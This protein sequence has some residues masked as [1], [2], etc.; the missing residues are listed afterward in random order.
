[1]EYKYDVFVSYN[2]LD[3]EITSQIVT[4]LESSGLKTFYDRSETPAGTIF[5]DF[6]Q[7]KL[8]SSRCILVI[9]S[10]NSLKSKWVQYEAMEGFRREVLVPI[11]ID[12]IEP[13]GIFKTQ[14]ILDFISFSSNNYESTIF[15]KLINDINNLITDRSFIPSTLTSSLNIEKTDLEKPDNHLFYCNKEGWYETKDHRLMIK[16][17]YKTEVDK[18]W[19]L[20][21]NEKMKQNDFD[22]SDFIFPH[23]TEDNFWL[24]D[25]KRVFPKSIYFQSARFIAG[26][27]FGSVDFKGITKFEGCHFSE[28]SYFQSANFSNPVNFNHSTFSGIADFGLSFFREQAVFNETKFKSNVKFNLALLEG[29]SMFIG[30]KFD[31]HASFDSASFRSKLFFADNILSHNSSFSFHKTEFSDSELTLFRNWSNSKFSAN[32]LLLEFSDVF[33]SEQ[34]EFLNFD[35]TAV[36]FIKCNLVKA[37]FI[38]G[39][40]PKRNNRIYFRNERYS[41][42]KSITDPQNNLSSKKTS[43]LEHYR[44]INSVYHQLK[45]SFIQAKNWE[46]ARDTYKS[47]MVTGL[48]ISKLRWQNKPMSFNLLTKFIIQYLHGLLSVYN[49]SII[50]PISLLLVAFISFALIYYLL[51]TYPIYSPN[52]RSMQISLINSAYYLFAIF[53]EINPGAWEGSSNPILLRSLIL[54]ERFIGSVLI[55]FL[56]LSFKARLK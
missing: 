50:R 23:F 54:I 31:K 3:S 27:N 2:N 7:Q 36:V 34:V 12:D 20:V 1:M 33:F 51:N 32:K 53:G 35:F 15:N 5:N 17:D 30:T 6:I 18:F 19:R 25:E 42:P 26:V 38:N 39:T 8:D 16:T 56:F 40:F 9:W 47:E 48:R 43:K 28:N 13:P 14:H 37:K 46:L 21:R 55:T 44:M 11:K 10:K 24:I 41:N 45:N 22:F 52:L 49:Q 29:S 4:G